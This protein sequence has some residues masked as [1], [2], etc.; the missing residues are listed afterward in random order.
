MAAVVPGA[1]GARGGYG[2]RFFLT[3]GAQVLSVEPLENGEV[4]TQVSTSGGHPCELVTSR[5]SCDDPCRCTNSQSC[6]IP[7]VRGQSSRKSSHTRVL[8]ESQPASQ[9]SLYTMG[10]Q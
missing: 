2:E 7:E 5:E 3:R 8:A 10:F 6:L 1:R 9:C 4:F